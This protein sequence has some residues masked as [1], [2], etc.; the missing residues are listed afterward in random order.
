MRWLPLESNPEVMNEWSSALGLSIDSVSFTDIYGLDE[1]LLGMIPTPVYAVLMLFPITEKYET[2]RAEENARVSKERAESDADELKKLDETIGNACGTMGL[3]HALAN[4]PDVPIA[5]GPL[6]SLI[7]RL[8]GKSPYER[9]KII[10]EDSELEK[11]HASTARTGQSRLPGE[12]EEVLLHFVCFVK[13]PQGNRLIELD[14]RKD[15]AIDHGPL[16][17]DL[18]HAVVPVVKKFMALADNDLQFNLIALC[19]TSQ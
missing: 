12:D 9:A 8:Q 17:G 16:E 4:N 1:E 14:G 15:F 7:S 3:L 13:S 11:V 19:P 10:E 2:F 18:L 5:P 6:K